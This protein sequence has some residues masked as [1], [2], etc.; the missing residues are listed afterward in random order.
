MDPIQDPEREQRLPDA[1]QQAFARLREERVPAEIDRAVLGRAADHFARRRR[2]RFTTVLGSSLAAAGVLAVAFL[3][4]QR[5]DSVE[6]Q[7]ARAEDVD[8]SGRVDILDA[9]ALARRLSRE[10]RPD[11]KLDFTHDGRVD[12]ADVDH[13]AQIAV[14]IGS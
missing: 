12:R 11:S 7:T 10:D 8:G 9:F 14:R 13:V 2:R 1:L 4:F 5:M 3:S 6:T